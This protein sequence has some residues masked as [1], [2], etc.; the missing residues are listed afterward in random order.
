MTAEFADIMYAFGYGGDIVQYFERFRRQLRVRND[1]PTAA[2]L[3]AGDLDRLR[4][5][6]EASDRR[7][8]AEAN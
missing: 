5:L 7:A 2:A 4:S 3:S 6:Y 1:I 8:R